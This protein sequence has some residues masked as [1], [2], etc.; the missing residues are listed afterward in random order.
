[1]NHDFRNNH[2]RH[3]HRTG[4]SG[5]RHHHPIPPPPPSPNPVP[6]PPP[7]A[8][9]IFFLLLMAMVQGGWDGTRIPIILPGGLTAMQCDT[10]QSI[11][12]LPLIKFSSTGLVSVAENSATSW[13]DVLFFFEK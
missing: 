8:G 13:W 6:P 4:D 7:A 10:I 3:D 5:A 2:H 12:F 11:I 1:M 9:I